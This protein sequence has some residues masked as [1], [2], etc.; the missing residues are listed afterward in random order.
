MKYFFQGSGK[1]LPDN[2]T[3]KASQNSLINP[4]SDINFNK[5]WSIKSGPGKL[6]FF[7]KSM[8]SS[9]FSNFILKS[10][11]EEAFFLLHSI[12]LGV[13]SSETNLDI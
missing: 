8:I 9:S 4:G 7:D 13:T 10:K 1:Y 2:I 11:K 6:L 12:K 5:I 3:S